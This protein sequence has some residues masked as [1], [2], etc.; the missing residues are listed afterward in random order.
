MKLHDIEDADQIVTKD[1]LDARLERLEK[2]VLKQI[3]ASER[4]T[5]GLL[6]AL[7]LGAYGGILGTYAFIIAAVYVNHFW[8]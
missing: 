5:R 2:E 1:Y 6:I 8:R 3:T 7:M 4:A